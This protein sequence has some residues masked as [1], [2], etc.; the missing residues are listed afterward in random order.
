MRIR[1]FHDVDYAP[2]SRLL[3]RMQVNP[4]RAAEMTPERLRQELASRGNNPHENFLVLETT[5]TAGQVVGFCG[6][7]PMPQGRALMEGPILEE[8]WRGQ[9]W[10]T[11]LW[12]ELSAVMGARGVRTVSIV[13]G[14]E[15][16][17]GAEFALRQ[18]FRHEKT[19]VIVVSEARS[20]PPA[21]APEGIRISL[22]GPDLDLVTYE[23]LHARLFTRRSPAYVGLLAR[24]P[25]YRILVAREGQDLV[26]LVELEFLDGVASLEAFG[27]APERRRRGLGRALLATALDIAWDQPGT[28]LVRQIWN[29]TEPGYLDLYLAMGFTCKY[30]IRGLVREVNGRQAV[31]A[32]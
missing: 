29:T 20:H 17:C 4:T 5:D 13:L 12:Q 26:G 1:F 3:T 23:D 32:K 21:P 25:T 2:L 7:Q 16:E 24:M 15:N 19:E 18:G 22:A 31:P 8:E 27:V 30:A 14:S 6:Y 11:R 10:A 9:G 28:T